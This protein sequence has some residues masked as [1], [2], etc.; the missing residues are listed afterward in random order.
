[1][2]AIESAG[3]IICLWNPASFREASRFSHL[4]FV[5][6]KGN[7]VARDAPERF[8]CIYAPTD[9]SCRVSSDL[10]FFVSN[11]ECRDFSIFDDFNA[12]LSDDERW[13]AMASILRLMSW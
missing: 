1:M 10:A 6:I 8:I 13:G 12:V 5:A 2:S 9:H 11:W 7:W 4:W 3:G